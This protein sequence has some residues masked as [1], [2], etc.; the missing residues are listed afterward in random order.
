MANT[1][2]LIKAKLVDDVVYYNL[3]ADMIAALR[4]HLM[5]A[6]SLQDDHYR[7]SNLIVKELKTRGVEIA[8]E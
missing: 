3:I 1:A 2:N 5:V 8:D 4:I 7:I 6:F